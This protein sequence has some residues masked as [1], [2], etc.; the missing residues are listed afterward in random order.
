MGEVLVMARVSAE[1]EAEVPGEASVAGTALA[2]VTIG[3]DISL[4]LEGEIGRDMAGFIP[5]TPQ[6]S[7]ICSKLMPMP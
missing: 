7:W 2:G 6:K 4:A 3:A 5:W 1:V